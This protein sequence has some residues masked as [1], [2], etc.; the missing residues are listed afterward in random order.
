MP[1]KV[2]VQSNEKVRRDFFERKG[3]LKPKVINTAVLRIT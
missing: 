2:K 3:K 1:M